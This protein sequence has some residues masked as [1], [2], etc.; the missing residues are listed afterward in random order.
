[1]PGVLMCVTAAIATATPQPPD[2]LLIVW[3]DVGIDQAAAFGW[4][5]A[6]S[7]MPV[8]E[9]ICDKSVRFTNA[10]AMPECTPTRAALMT[11]RYPMRTRPLAPCI[12]GMVPPPQLNPAETTLPDLLR[13]AGYDTA[14]VG[15][16][17]LGENGPTGPNSPASDCRLDFFTG[18]LNIPPSIDWTVGG[19]APGP[20]GEGVFSCGRRLARAPAALRTPGVGRT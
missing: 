14:M 20:T 19:Q 6:Q 2:I 18:S 8:F 9:A 3:D 16:Y 12:S 13:G 15:K 5:H 7:Q 10:W 4:T 11:G 17:H 1:M